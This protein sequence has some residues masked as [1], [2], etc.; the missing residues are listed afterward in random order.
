MGFLIF[1][2]ICNIPYLTTAVRCPFNGIEKNLCLLQGKA[3]PYP[4]MFREDT[5][6][7]KVFF[8]GRILKNVQNLM[9][10]KKKEENLLV[11]F[12]TGQ[13]RSADTY[14]YS[15]FFENINSHIF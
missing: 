8:S 4:N 5:H 2:S 14:G 9:K 7:K 6:M 11:M 12:S 15:T 1:L 13:N 3:R 10:R